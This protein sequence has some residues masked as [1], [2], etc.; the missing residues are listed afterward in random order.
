MGDS[1]GEKLVIFLICMATMFILALMGGYRLP[2][3]RCRVD[4]CMN[5]R[6]PY[7]S[8][9]SVHK[10]EREKEYSRSSG[11]YRSYADKSRDDGTSGTG[12]SYTTKRSYGTT[13]SGTGNTLYNDPAD[14]DN[15]DDY[16]DDAWGNDFEDWDDAY[17]YWEDY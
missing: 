6:L 1:G 17:E 8:Y 3:D 5:E 4:G 16:A 15:P 9:C 7:S 10:A 12:R 13:G 2:W 14:Y 11:S